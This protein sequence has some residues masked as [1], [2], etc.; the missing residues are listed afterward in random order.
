MKMKLSIK[1]RLNFGSILPKENDYV[2]SLL[3]RDILKKIDLSQEEIKKIE[4]KNV[5]NQLS[6]KN[7]LDKDIEV[8][9][10][11]AEL[12]VLNEAINK[13]DKANKI[14]LSNL[15]I[16]EKIKDYKKDIEKK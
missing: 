16:I 1:E 6:W 11:A 10:T 8:E 14:S 7:N 9:F 3:S 13:L 15:D 2:S 4:L 12:N 5:N